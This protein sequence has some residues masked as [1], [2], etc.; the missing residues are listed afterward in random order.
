[1][2]PWWAKDTS[3]K[4]KYKIIDSKHLTGDEVTVHI[5]ILPYTMKIFEH[6]NWPQMLFFSYQKSKV[7]PLVSSHHFLKHSTAFLRSQNTCFCW[8]SAFW[9][10]LQNSSERTWKSLWVFS[11][12]HS[13]SLTWVCTKQTESSLNGTPGRKG[14]RKMNCK[15]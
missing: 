2:Q 12:L 3:F 13:R 8:S 15:L 14:E 6:L 7:Y 1:M 11:A 5:Y 9:R 4:N 10:D